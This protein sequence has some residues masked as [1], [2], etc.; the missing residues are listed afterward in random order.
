[1][2]MAT[3]F[4]KFRSRKRRPKKGSST[5]RMRALRERREET[6]DAIYFFLPKA[7]AMMLRAYAAEKGLSLS[8]ALRKILDAHFEVSR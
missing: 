1:M 4:Y 3:S 7:S 6:H 2:E 5:S 8:D